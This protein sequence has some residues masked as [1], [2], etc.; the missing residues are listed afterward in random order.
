MRI[1]VMVQAFWIALFSIFLLAAAAN[2]GPINVD[3]NGV[4]IQG[5]DPVAYFTD[6]KPMQGTDEFTS[7][8]EGAIY[9]F[10]SAD[11][12]AMF[13]AEPA[14]FTPQYGGY[15]AYGLAQGSKASVE[16]DKFTVVDG[17]LYLNFNGDIQ[18]RWAKDISGYVSK[19]DKNW[20]AMK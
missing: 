15:C 16:V 5:Y 3:G 17:K 10:A 7:K 20:S 1:V 19:A 14:K 4:A 8:H 6:G 12:K 11:H 2:A 13:D 18:N 9:K